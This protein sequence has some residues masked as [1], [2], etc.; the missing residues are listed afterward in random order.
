LT[1]DDPDLERDAHRVA[2]LAL[3]DGPAQEA[4]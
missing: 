2:S 4:A 1:L 3:Y